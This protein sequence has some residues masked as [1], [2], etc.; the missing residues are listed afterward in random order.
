LL[1]KHH[2]R[3]CPAE[4]RNGVVEPSSFPRGTA[5]TI[6]FAEKYAACRYWALT[7]G[8]QVPWYLAEAADGFQIRPGRCDPALPQTPHRVGIQVGMADGSVRAFASSVD[9]EVWYAA[10]TPEAGEGV[11]GK[12]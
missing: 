8:P 4:L 11:G 2:V 3:L 12:P 10:N 5:N 6:L 7:S 1:F 9:R